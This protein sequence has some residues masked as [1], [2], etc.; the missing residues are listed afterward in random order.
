MLYNN[1]LETI[2]KTPLVK[3]N[4][5]SYD[6]VNIYGKLEYFNPSGSVKDRAA[7]NM[8]LE[9]LSSG[10]IDNEAVI[11]EPTSGNMGIGLAMVCAS[12][13]MKLILTM[14]ENMS[15]E[16]IKIL[17]AYGA[18]VVLTPKAQGMKG[19]IE[20]AERLKAQHGHAFI[21]SQFT[22]PANS[23]AHFLNTAKEIFSDLNNVSWIV[24]GIGSGGTIMGIK[25]YV[26]TYNCAAQICGVEPKGSPLLSRGKAGPHKIQ[27]IGANFVPKI[28][29]PDLLDTVEDVSDAEAI[30]CAKELA[31]QEGI[32][33][34]I[35]SGA[36]L[37][38]AKNLSAR[39]EK[40]NIVVILPDG[41]MKY[42]STELA[43]D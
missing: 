1:V 14:P 9:A 15:V 21:P 7:Y 16:R 8:I 2:G 31:R 26:D 13:G 6:D 33:V 23:A 20:K 38:A 12:M 35:S 25:K 32:F 39:G 11:I 41:G 42:L 22:N 37:Q 36:A 10:E 30:E 18:E 3:L 19:S 24:A 17:K 29:N 43:D 40:G 27:G 4:S 34:G 28:L 5:L